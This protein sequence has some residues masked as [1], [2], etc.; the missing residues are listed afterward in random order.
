MIHAR[1]VTCPYSVEWLGSFCI[2]AKKKSVLLSVNPPCAS[3]SFC[4][5]L[6]R[7]LSERTFGDHRKKC[8]DQTFVARAYFMP[9]NV[10]LYRTWMYSDRHLWRSSAFV[11][12]KIFPSNEWTARR[13]QNTYMLFCYGKTVLKARVKYINIHIYIVLL[14]IFLTTNSYNSL[15]SYT[16]VVLLSLFINFLKLMFQK[17]RLPKLF[18]RCNVF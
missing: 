2:A 15:G 5:A 10:K 11:K 4:V 13:E 9:S 17:R 16:N 1:P 3:R 14:H 18:R 8:Y 6:R 12:K 7:L